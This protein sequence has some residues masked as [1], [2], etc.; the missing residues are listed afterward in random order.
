MCC[1]TKRTKVS[2]LMN[3]R[4]QSG[5]TLVG[6]AAVTVAVTLLA[7]ASVPLLENAVFAANLSSIS[8]RGRDIFI[9]ITGANTEREPLGLPPVWPADKGFYTNAV[10]GDI[11]SVSFT[12][13]T[14][15]FRFLYDEAH[16]GTARWKPH[17]ADFDYSKVSGCGVSMC[18]DGRLTPDHNIWTIAKN[19]HD[20]LPDVVPVL[21]TR[22][23][24][25]SSLAVTVSAEEAAKKV[26]FE[27]PLKS[28]GGNKGLVAIRKGGSIFKARPKYMVYSVIYGNTTFDGTRDR[29]GAPVRAPLGYLTPVGTA[30]PGKAAP[31]DGWARV[32]RLLK[33]VWRDLVAVRPIGLWVCIVYLVLAVVCLW[34]RVRDRDLFRLF[35]YSAVFWVSHGLAAFFWCAGIF[36][37]GLLNVSFWWPFVT[38]AL[39]AQ[40][41]GFLNIARSRKADP[42]SF[43][44]G[45]RFLLAVPLLVG[46]IVALPVTVVWILVLCVS[47]FS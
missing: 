43:Q 26:Q 8:A 15:Y 25:A 3:I 16:A 23:I 36:G 47:A 12:N 44:R 19:V 1:F 28:P 27:W 32:S 33:A 46:G 14:E 31:A 21:I 6:L 42:A 4:W 30:V 35:D 29:L 39:L 2:L 45:M 41:V 17:V 34:M 18:T 22:N 9:S 11:S 38:F 24:D 7:L 10:A 13:S 40:L 20:D 5:F 37:S